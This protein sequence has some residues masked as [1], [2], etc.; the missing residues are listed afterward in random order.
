ME[1]NTQAV[2]WAHIRGDGLGETTMD[3]RIDQ[4]LHVPF[5]E[6]RQVVEVGVDST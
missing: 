6:N 1:F 4:A 3:E 5:G 2:I